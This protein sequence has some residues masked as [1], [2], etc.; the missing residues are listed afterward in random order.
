MNNPS[1][2]VDLNIVLYLTL[3]EWSSIYAKGP[4]LPLLLAL[5]HQEEEREV[6]SVHNYSTGYNAMELLSATYPCEQIYIRKN[7]AAANQPLLVCSIWWP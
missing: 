6:C 5:Q 4:S 1:T 3:H 7:F 2:D